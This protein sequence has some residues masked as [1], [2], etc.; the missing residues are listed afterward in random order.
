MMDE[1]ERR[2]LSSLRFDW[3]PSPDTVWRPPPC[4][5]ERLNR[6]ALELILT[7][8]GDAKRSPDASPLGVVLVGQRGSGK[9]HILSAARE[10]VQAEG[11]FFFLVSLLDAGAFW[12]S[13]ILSIL[14]G[15]LRTALGGEP[16]LST[17]LRDLT[18]QL[19]T[20]R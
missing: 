10:R 7:G 15:L 12:H 5:V 20:P 19:G 4:H 14:D 18:D 13:T 8:F 6:E 2:A 11:G 16:Q 9:T 17:F 1:T 3:A